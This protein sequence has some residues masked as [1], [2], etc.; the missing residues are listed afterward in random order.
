MAINREVWENE[1]DALRQICEEM[2]KLYSRINWILEHN[3]DLSIDWGAAEKPAYFTEAEDGNLDT[4]PFTRQ[5]IA[6]A[7][8]SLSQV[9]NLL[10]NQAVSQGDHLGNLNVVARPLR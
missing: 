10:T 4:R 6:N 5:A 3:S 8:G 9:R 1:A 2:V 7:V